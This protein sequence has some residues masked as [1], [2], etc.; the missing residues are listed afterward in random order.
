MSSRF[1]GSLLLL[2][3]LSL[4]QT[5]Y[6]KPSPQELAVRAVSGD[7]SESVTAIEELRSIGPTGLTVMYQVHAAEIERQV[8]NPLLESTPEWRRLSAALDSVS[9]QKN[10]YLSG[11]YW[12]TDFARARAAAKSSGKPILSLRL[13]GN[14]SEEFSCANSR[15]FRAVLYSN[16]EIS[17]TLRENFVLHWQSVRPAPRVTID[18]GDGRKLERTLTGNS[19]HYFLDADG[20]TIDGLPGLYGP[21]AFQRKLSEIQKLTR[22]LRGKDATQQAG[23]L[24]VYHRARVN[25]ISLDWIDEIKLLDGKVPA[26]LRIEKDQNGQAIVV[27]PTAITKMYSE[28]TILRAITAGSE[29]LG[30]LTDEAAWTKIAQRHIADAQMDERSTGLLRRQTQKILDAPLSPGETA[31]TRLMKLLSKL[32]LSMALDTVRNEY[33]L[34][35]KLHAWLVADPTR[36]DLN[37]L[38]EKVYSELFLTPSTDPWLGLFSADT[39]VA[40]EN[41]GL[42]R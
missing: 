3:L 18:F 30:R 24:N 25:Q 13:L 9:Q 35:T 6:A 12:Y 34:H 1:P 27:A 22:N 4:V 42:E 38:N 14:L 21:V 28:A 36:F 39:Y 7:A 11:L 20:K 32:Q 2:L 17:R 16:S 15:F 33:L 26:G 41:G 40:L 37:K 31:D 23:M 29:A 10:S 5:V 19:I 8:K